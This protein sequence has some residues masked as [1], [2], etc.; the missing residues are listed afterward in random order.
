[1]FGKKIGETPFYLRT[2]F[3]SQ[4]LRAF[5]SNKNLILYFWKANNSI[6]T[7][8]SLLKL[9]FLVHDTIQWLN[10]VVHYLNIKIK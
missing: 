9:Y 3:L 2:I 10:C 6:A 8:H 1:M 5:L 4:I 7:Q